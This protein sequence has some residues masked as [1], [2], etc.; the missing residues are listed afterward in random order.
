M[1]YPMRYLDATL[2]FVRRD[3]TFLILGDSA[4]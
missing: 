2:D 1:Q 3:I 4:K